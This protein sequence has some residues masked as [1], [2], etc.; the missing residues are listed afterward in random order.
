MDVEIDCTIAAAPEDV[1]A[2][3]QTSRLLRHITF[4]LAV[5]ISREP[6]GFPEVWPEGAHRVWIFILGFLPFGSQ[7]IRIS[8]Q[9]PDASGTF[10]IR[11]QGSGWMVPVWDHHIEIAPAGEGQTAYRDTVH[12]KA[13]PL[14]PIVWSYAAVFYRWRQWRWRQLA[15]DGFK[16]LDGATRG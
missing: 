11:D 10:K 3:V 2:R 15:R 4:P 7:T 5:F 14:T 8:R 13:G 9:G 6:G 16:A 12:I 1:I